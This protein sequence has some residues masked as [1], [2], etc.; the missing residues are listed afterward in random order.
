MNYLTYRC[1]PI[2]CY[3]SRSKWTWEWWQWRGT[4]HSLNLQRYWNLTIRL[5]SVIYWTIIRGLTRLQ[6]STDR[7]DN[8][9]HSLV[10]FNFIAEKQSVYYTAPADRTSQDTR[11]R[12]LT[13]LQRNSRCLLLL[14]LTGQDN[15]LVYNIADKT[16]TIQ[17]ENAS[18]LEDALVNLAINFW[19][20]IFKIHNLKFRHF[21]IEFVG[22]FL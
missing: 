1:N 10:G 17:R 12:G 13:F 11:W 5:L 3:H 22:I 6:W 4:Q 8:S 9:G 21:F 7:Q 2:K 16:S 20:N 19:F 14:P 18:I 15:Y